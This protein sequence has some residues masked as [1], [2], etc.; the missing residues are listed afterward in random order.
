[1]V[2]TAAEPRAVTRVTAGAPTG[3]VGCD[4][5]QGRGRTH[6][7]Q[8]RAARAEPTRAEAQLCSQGPHPRAGAGAVQTTFAPA[9]V[10][11]RALELDA[12]HLPS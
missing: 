3:L 6:I 7:S 1:M 2:Y 10:L 11:L 8:V 5:A 4:A 12:G 9:A